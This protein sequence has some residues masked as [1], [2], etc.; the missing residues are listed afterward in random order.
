LVPGNIDFLATGPIK[1]AEKRFPGR[2]YHIHN[3]AITAVRTER[4]ELEAVAQVLAQRCNAAR[5]P[6]SILVPLGGFSVFDHQG[7]PFHDPEGPE[8]FG[9]ALERHLQSGE[10]LHLLPYHI[11]D[12]EFS[13]AVL[14]ALE[15]LLENKFKQDKRR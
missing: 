10:S 3:A 1:E 9:K 14:R 15:Q 4:I 7:D 13:E 11:N 6:F 2:I 8:I 12:P 5:G